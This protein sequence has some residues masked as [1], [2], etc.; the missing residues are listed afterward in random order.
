[1]GT[2]WEYALVIE[3]Y[4][5]TQTRRGQWETHLGFEIWRPGVATPETPALHQLAD[6][7]AMM[8]HLGS[9]GWE[10]VETTI[11]QST[12]LPAIYGD[13]EGSH[14]VK[15]QYIFRRVIA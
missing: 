8:N 12:I 14:P 15:M 1:M 3:R 2:R 5:A 13:S 10:Y 9:E 6:W 11:V 7:L 4:T